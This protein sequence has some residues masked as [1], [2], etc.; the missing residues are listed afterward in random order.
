MDAR[1][2]GSVS[3]SCLVAARWADARKS[4]YL[5][6]RV[7][8]K[9]KLA[10]EWPIQILVCPSPINHGELLGLVQLQLKAHEQVLDHAACR[11]S[12]HPRGKRARHA[13]GP[14]FHFPFPLDLV[15]MSLHSKGS[16]MCMLQRAM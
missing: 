2:G 10:S 7:V 9:P 13:Q 12:L 1:G 15:H 3:I 5:A 14:I 6:E 16:P 4:Q 8:N 11:F